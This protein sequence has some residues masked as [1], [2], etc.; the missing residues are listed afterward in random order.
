MHVKCDLTG[1]PAEI[2]RE[3]RDRGHVV[4]IKDAVSQG[5]YRLYDE[6]LE[7]DM[8]KVRVQAAKRLEE[9]T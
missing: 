7:R 5:L 8:L 1:E 3:L 9:D 2:L 4:S 6:V